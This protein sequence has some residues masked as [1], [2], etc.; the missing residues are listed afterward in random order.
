[1]TDNRA[2]SSLWPC[3]RPGSSGYFQAPYVST[4]A[5]DRIAIGFPLG[6]GTVTVCYVTRKDARL[7]AKRLNQ[8]LDATVKP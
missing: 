4:A 6:D 5:A 8:C 7:L 2:P 1:M 3:R